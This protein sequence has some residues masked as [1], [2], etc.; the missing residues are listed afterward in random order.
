MKSLFSIRIIIAIL[1][2]TMY[3][4]SCGTD[5]IEPSVSGPKVDF[6]AGAGLITSDAS[7]F[8][9]KEF[10]VNIVGSKTNN[11]L[12]TLTIHEEGTLVPLDRLVGISA[13]PMSLSGSNATSF[14]FTITIKAHLDISSKK[15][16]FLVADLKGNM[17]NRSILIGA[18]PLPPTV[19]LL[20]SSGNIDIAPNLLIP[21]PFKVTKGTSNLKTIEV[22]I[23]DVKAQDF[24]KILFGEVLLTPFDAN[25]FTLPA[26]AK[27]K[28][29][30]KIF[31]RTSEVAGTYK[32]TFTFT[33]ER[34][35]YGS[36]DLIV[37]VG[38]AINNLEGVLLNQGGP[39][40]QG[41]VDLDTGASS[42]SADAKTEIRDE[43]N[44][45]VTDQ[46]WKQQISGVNGSEIRY[47]VKGMGGVAESFNFANI[48]F[49]EEV[50]SLFSKGVT[51]T[52]KSTDDLRFVSNKVSIGDVFSVKN[53]SKYYLL[54]IKDVK[55]TT[56]DNKDQYTFD[57]KF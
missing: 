12:K 48:K 22:L 2:T 9:G 26:S 49:K 10:K 17:T 52:Q 11:R 18:L 1:A 44:L 30:D 15:Y 23:N 47:I 21:V 41:G 31:I 19:E 3:L 43:G 40:S 27:D 28:F 39:V 16:S 57:A 6:I 34:G 37:N 24:T 35:S 7:V 8:I 46:T 45:S 53:G 4:I 42:G 50:A 29:E 54:L 25:P 36:K 33:D 56:N 20:L 5:D 55:A 13:N 38:N 32:Y 51:F 14:D